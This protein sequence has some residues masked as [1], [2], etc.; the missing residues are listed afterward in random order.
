MLN[1]IKFIDEENN[2]EYTAKVLAWIEA[3]NKVNDCAEISFWSNRKI[4]VSAFKRCEAM[5]VV[6][7]QDEVIAYMIWSASDGRLHIDI[8]EVSKEFRRKGIFKAMITALTEKFNDLL[9]LSASPIQQSMN[10]FKA[11]G[12]EMVVDKNG[13]SKCYKI[14]RPGLFFQNT[15][16]D[17]LVIAIFSKT[18]VVNPNEYVDYYR[19]KERPNHYVLKYFQIELDEERKLKMPIVTLFHVDGY[20]GIYLNKKLITDGKTKHLFTNTV[21][22]DDISLLILERI[23]PCNLELLTDFFAQGQ[24][25]PP[26]TSSKKSVSSISTRSAAEPDNQSD[27]P[28]IKRRLRSS[29]A[30]FKLHEPLKQHQAKSPSFFSS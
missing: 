15:L 27:H 8:V 14:L 7:N 3:N 9:V 2:S 24:K 25:K 1:R 17:G 28:N 29:S 23:S 26:V 18:D 19:V 13:N 16:P 5:V 4:I 12:W 11:L 20:V 21:A 22:H 10:V 6:N 30:F